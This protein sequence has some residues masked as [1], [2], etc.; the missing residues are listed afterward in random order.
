MGC[1]FE[2]RDAIFLAHSTVSN[3]ILLVL[4]RFPNLF[5]FPIGQFPLSSFPLDI[6]DES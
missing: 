3:I 4:Q 6:R 5:Q 1:A 2:M